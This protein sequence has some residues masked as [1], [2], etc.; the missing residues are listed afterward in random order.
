[1]NTQSVNIPKTSLTLILAAVLGGISLGLVSLG[2]TG[3]HPTKDN[4]LH[5]RIADNGDRSKDAPALTPTPTPTPTPFSH[6][7][8]F[9]PVDTNANVSIGID[10]A[11]V[12]I[13]DGPCTNMWTY[14]GTYPGLTIRRP[15]GQTTSVTF[16]N[17]L[18]PAAGELTVHNHGNHSTATNDGQPD[19]L[20]ILTGGSRT[21]IYDGLEEGAN[22]RGKMQFYHDHRM[23]VTGRNVW[24]G[25]TGMY[26][27]D[28]PLIRRRYPQGPSTFLWPLPIGNSTQTTKSH[29]C[30]TL[31]V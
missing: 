13:L 16:T 19:T 26:I 24:M 10:Q 20:L 15:T 7:L 29:T 4:K 25:L 31:M 2:S 14:G 23:D 21:Y 11:C 8:V 30:L 12:Q 6:P 5:E 22:Q 28:D 27:V 9:P 18:D 1:M 17:N 3:S